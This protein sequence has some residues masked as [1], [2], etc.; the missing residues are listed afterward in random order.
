MLP[1]GSSR[2]DASRFPCTGAALSVSC[3]Q[4][5]P[6]ICFFGEKSP[7]GDAAQIFW[8][9]SPFFLNSIRQNAS[10]FK[11]RVAT[12]MPTGY[13]FNAPEE[14]YGRLREL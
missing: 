2:T 1:A 5:E 4:V 10:L 7:K 9:K 14:K 8:G 13:T 12:S 3:T 11:E 6:A